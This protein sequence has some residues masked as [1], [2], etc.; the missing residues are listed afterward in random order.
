[1]ERDVWERV[2]F[3]NSYKKPFLFYVL[4]GTD[5]MD[6]LSVSREKHNVDGMPDG[7][8]IASYSKSESDE[9]RGYIR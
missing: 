5:K 8:E 7:L 2:Y 9:Q 1:M 4:F 6:E 3:T